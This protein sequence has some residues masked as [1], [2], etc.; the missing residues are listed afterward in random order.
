MKD[1]DF[2]KYGKYVQ[3]LFIII[4]FAAA[5]IRLSMKAGLDLLFCAYVNWVAII[6]CVLIVLF[7]AH[8][9]MKQ[10]HKNCLSKY[11]S[12]SVMEKNIRIYEIFMLAT[13]VI[14]AIIL[15]FILV[16]N[17]T[18]TKN[19]IST[20]VTLT[21]AISTDVITD[22]FAALFYSC[23]SIFIRKAS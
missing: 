6:V 15:F 13:M 3:I 4:G 11:P 9:K 22:F 14:S 20:I 21:L 23:K 16:P 10:H 8:S 17:P 1:K 5:F 19:D 12:A 18:G 7:T 2:I